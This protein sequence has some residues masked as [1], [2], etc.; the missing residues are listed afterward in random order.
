MNAGILALGAFLVVGFVAPFC[1]PVAASA[2]MPC[3]K[4]SK[5]CDLGMKAAGCCRLDPVPSAASGVAL[6]APA[7]KSHSKHGPVPGAVSEA[8]QPGTT[9][10]VALLRMCRHSTPAIHGSAPPIYLLNASILR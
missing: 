6:Q 1:S 10:S 2:A 3:C 9:A 7:P 4:T 5:Q 8:I